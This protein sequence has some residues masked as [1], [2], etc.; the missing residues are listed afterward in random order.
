M[1]CTTE[2]EAVIFGNKDVIVFHILIQKIKSKKSWEPQKTVGEEK[3]KKMRI[4]SQNL[5]WMQCATAM[6]IF[7]AILP[8]GAS[9]SG[10]NTDY[11]YSLLL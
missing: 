2:C 9:D 7:V 8:R 4:L 1:H 6:V 11:T 3:H 5:I 10:K